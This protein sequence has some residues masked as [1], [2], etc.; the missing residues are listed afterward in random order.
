[1]NSIHN[2]IMFYGGIR[3]NNQNMKETKGVKKGGGG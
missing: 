2:V 1:M 3:D